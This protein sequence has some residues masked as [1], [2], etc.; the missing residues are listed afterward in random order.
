MHRDPVIRIVALALNGS[1]PHFKTFL[2]SNRPSWQSLRPNVKV[3]STEI[4]IRLSRSAPLPGWHPD[5]PQVVGPGFV[6]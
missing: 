6:T 5:N 3:C 1:E 4:A 2:R